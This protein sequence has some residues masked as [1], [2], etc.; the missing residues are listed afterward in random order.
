MDEKETV[1]LPESFHF[2]KL[3][4]KKETLEANEPVFIKDQQELE[5]L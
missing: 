2:F 3:K 4:Y 5:G 1:I